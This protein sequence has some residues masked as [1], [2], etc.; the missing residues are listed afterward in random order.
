MLAA[1]APWQDVQARRWQVSV[2]ECEVKPNYT[3]H[4]VSVYDPESPFRFRPQCR[5]RLSRKLS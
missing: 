2:K 5:T 4:V 1:E 3:V